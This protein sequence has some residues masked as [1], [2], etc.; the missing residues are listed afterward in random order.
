LGSSDGSNDSAPSN[1]A[2]GNL[3]LN[4]TAS[5]DRQVVDSAEAQRIVVSR[6][7]PTD[8]AANRWQPSLASA[9]EQATESEVAYVEIRGEVTLDRPV[10]LS[11]CNLQLAGQPGARVIVDAAALAGSEHAAIRLREA[12]L[13]MNAL[14]VEL[15]AEM[16][17]SMTSQVDA[18]G[19]VLL[20]TP[21]CSLRVSNCEF[22]I[23]DLTAADETSVIVSR[24]QRT[25]I[26]I[27]AAVS[28]AAAS[29]VPGLRQPIDVGLGAVGQGIWN[30]LSP[31]DIS[32]EIRLVDSQ[33][34]G[35]GRLIR[36]L[37]ADPASQLDV[38]LEGCLV[39]M[40]EGAV[41]IESRNGNARPK[42]IQLNATR[43]TFISRE[44]FCTI[45]YAGDG[46]PQLQL[47]RSSKEC[48]FLNETGGHF[49]LKGA[50]RTSLFGTF[51][52]LQLEGGDN[53][54]SESTADELCAAFNGNT[55]SATFGFAEASVDGW[56]AEKS[57]E[58]QVTWQQP[59]ILP[60][61][62]SR[63]TRSDV[64]PQRRY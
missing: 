45:F 48:V 64:T 53:I 21:G 26:S 8:V 58:Y 34:R 7:P 43:C 24:Q 16:P 5:N 33:I 6:S 61:D 27:G 13:I 35:D 19:I 60:I 52:L 51:V 11:G 41:Q 54:Y 32:Q 12:G 49:A 2:L 47:R 14:A 44:P 57:N 56:F 42:S 40:S 17:A 55:I 46:L 28:G 23:D 63:L 39:A 22:T 10:V 62:Y 50:P 29:A 1:S 20:E 31:T 37:D 30:A 3:P 36:Y 9:L 4:N 59:L 18:R 38:T 25:P 15:I